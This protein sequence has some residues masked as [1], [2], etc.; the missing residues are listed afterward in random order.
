MYKKLQFRN[1]MLPYKKC[2][3]EKTTYVNKGCNH[4]KVS[5]AIY[6]V[7]NSPPPQKKN[8]EITILSISLRE[9]AQDSD[10]SFVFWEN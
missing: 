8:H 7:V 9:D 6:G 10:F 3:T 4:L 1:I 5:K 2:V